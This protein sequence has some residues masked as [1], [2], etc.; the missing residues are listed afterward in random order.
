MATHLNKLPNVD[1]EIKTTLTSSNEKIRNVITEML[2]KVGITQ[3]HPL[4]APPFF[5][6]R[7]LLRN[8]RNRNTADERHT[9]DPY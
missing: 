5:S 1:K 2:H 9:E 4:D 3:E 7:S 8:K 6:R